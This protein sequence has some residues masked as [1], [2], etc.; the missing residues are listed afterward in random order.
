MAKCSRAPGINEGH[1]LS[2][3]SHGYWICEY[4][5]GYKKRAAK[6]EGTSTTVIKGGKWGNKADKELSKGKSRVNPDGKSGKGGCAGAFIGL[7]ALG[8]GLLYA[9][10]DTIWRFVA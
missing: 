1:S 5:C 6:T 4:G 7:A 9:A 10:A 3:N 2:L 8:G